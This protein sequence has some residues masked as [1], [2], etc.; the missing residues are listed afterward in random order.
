MRTCLAQDLQADIAQINVKATTTDGIG[1]TG[2]GDGIASLAVA[3][4]NEIQ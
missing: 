1:F 3:T 2:R 4:L